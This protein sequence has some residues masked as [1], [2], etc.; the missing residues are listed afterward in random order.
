MKKEQLGQRVR[1]LRT[2][3]NISVDELAEKL[4]SSASYVGLLERGDR[5]LTLG[6]LV[7]VSEMFDVSLDYLVFGDSARGSGRDS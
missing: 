5:T 4:E 3:R 1:E 6:Q 2:S 7:V